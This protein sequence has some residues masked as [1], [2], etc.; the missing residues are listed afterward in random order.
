MAVVLA[1][2]AG[3][4]DAVGYMVLA[5][6]FIANMSGNSVQLGIYLAE[7][8]WGAVLLHGFPVP[9][10]FVGVALGTLMVD[11]AARRASRSSFAPVFGLE[12]LAI[13][14]FLF[15][16]SRYVRDGIIPVDVGWQFYALVGLVTLAMGLQTATLHRVSGL[17]VRTTYVTGVLTDLAHECTQYGL[18]LVDSAHSHPA[19]E[20]RDLAVSEKWRSLG[21]IR[22]LAGVWSS[23]VIGAVCGGFLELRLALASLALP[24][25]F[26]LSLAL[27]DLVSPINVAP[28]AD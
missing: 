7:E 12:A 2:V 18:A 27:F 28:R 23:Y 8:D 19:S 25:V 22:L 21:R 14:V 15:Y 5:H 16:G 20:A 10:F 26:I 6:V 13:V 17:N 1:F 24:L 4:V 3:G 11:L 9:L